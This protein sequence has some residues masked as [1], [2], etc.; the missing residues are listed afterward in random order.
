MWD[1]ANQLNRVASLLCMTVAVALALTLVLWVAGQPTFAYREV[2]MKAPLKR[3]S[4]V[5]IEAVIREELSGTFF[6][7]NL[8]DARRALQAV[9]W[10]R[11]VGLRRLWPHHLQVTVE[12]HEPLA[13][14]NDSEL[15]NTRGE[16][17]SADWNEELPLLAGPAARAAEVATRYRAWSEL[18][19]PLAMHI[20]E[21]RVSARGSWL[22]RA[23]TPERALTLELGREEPEQRL[24]RFV[25]AHSRSIGALERS[26]IKVEQI[27]LRYRNGFAVRVPGFRER[28]LPQ[29]IGNPKTGP[30]ASTRKSAW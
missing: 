17:F 16:V 14:W 30:L 27:D 8:D 19:A 23:L 15:V 2:R 1:N 6:T 22:V 29:R 4:A 11:T 26:G 25:A 21:I 7:M 18:L 10:I 5:H 9:P 24:A 12:E 3:A 13:R 28:V 20:A